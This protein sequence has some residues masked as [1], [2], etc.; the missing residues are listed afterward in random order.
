MCSSDLDAIVGGT[1]GYRSLVDAEPPSDLADLPRWLGATLFNPASALFSEPEYLLREDPRI[2]D[3][4]IYHAIL[5]AIA[6][7]HARPTA[8]GGAIGRERTAL[9]YPLDV[10]TTAGFV[11]RRED[12]RRARGATD[13]IGTMMEKFA[14]IPRCTPCC[15]ANARAR[16]HHTPPWGLRQWCGRGNTRESPRLQPFAVANEIVEI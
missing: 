10:L 12:L 16:P 7:G 14:K 13:A 5:R 6:R 2:Q 8:I 9:S 3:R 1:P 4:A 11:T 15:E